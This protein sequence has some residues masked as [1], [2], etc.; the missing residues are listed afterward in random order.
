LDSGKGSNHHRCRQFCGRWVASDPPKGATVDRIDGDALPL[1][2]ACAD[3]RI[4]DSVAALALRARRARSTESPPHRLPF[5][6]QARSAER[7]KWTRVSRGHDRAPVLFHRGVR[8]A[9]RS[10]STAARTCGLEPA[11][12]GDEFRGP[13]LCQIL[14][15]RRGLDRADCFEFL[16]QIQLSNVRLRFT[17][18]F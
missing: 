14:L 1:G 4:L 15:S 17:Y 12:V 13:S 8:P 2:T 7:W 18:F 9:V 11:Q 5:L 3:E 10:R 16:G 6:S